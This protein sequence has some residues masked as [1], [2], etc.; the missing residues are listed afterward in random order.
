MRRPSTGHNDGD[1]SRLTSASSHSNGSVNSAQS[2]IHGNNHQSGSRSKVD[3]DINDSNNNN[4]SKYLPNFINPAD[5][6]NCRKRKER[7]D[8]TSS[9]TQDR[10]LVRSNSEEHVPNCQEVIRRVASHEDFKKPNPLQQHNENEHTVRESEKLLKEFRDASPED[11]GNSS[12]LKEQLVE[13][14]SRT[15]LIDV[16]TRSSRLSPSRDT[17]RNHNR[18]DD[19]EHEHEKRRNS[20]RFLKTR[21]PSGRKSPRKSSAKKESNKHLDRDENLYKYDRNSMKHERRGFVSQRESIDE[22]AIAEVVQ[23]NQNDSSFDETEEQTTSEVVHPWNQSFTEDTGPVVCQR[24]ADHKFDHVHNS[25]AKYTKNDDYIRYSS[26]NEETDNKSFFLNAENLKTR[27]LM[28]K[29][30]I[31]PAVKT[32]LTPDER[33]KKINKRLASL[34]KKIGL[35]EESFERDYGYRL[36]QA[37][38][39][40]DRS[41]K[42]YTSEIHKLKKEKS[43]IKSDPM[44]AMGYKS[45]LSDTAEADIKLHKMKDTLQEIE[46]VIESIKSQF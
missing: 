43:Q 30:M 45:S 39:T 9:I 18:L 33:I 44:A 14:T 22:V 27:E 10:K 36:S 28:Q 46:K 37:D 1:L 31:M 17:H 19:A 11:E 15:R 35:Y 26:L 41:I 38:K 4:S 40:N 3:S 16:L 8:S 6:Q 32:F 23:A 12:S 13:S 24:F 5:W 42:N 29:R 2:I 20:E 25:I 21:A 34:K 7:Q